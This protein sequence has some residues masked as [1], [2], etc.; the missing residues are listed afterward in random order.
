MTVSNKPRIC[1][2]LGVEIGERF[3]VDYPKGMTSWLH[4]N[5]DG[6]VERDGG[7]NRFKVGNSIAWAINHPESIVREPR[8]TEQDVEDAKALRRLYPAAFVLARGCY[9]HLIVGTAGRVVMF[10]L[11]PSNKSFPSIR[12]GMQADLDEILNQKRG[13]RR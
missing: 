9:G 4:I 12:P 3:R 5:E 2:I 11:P 8:F 6:F 10:V 1:K 7:A 13:E